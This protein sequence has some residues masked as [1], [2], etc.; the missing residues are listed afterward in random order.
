MTPEQVINKDSQTLNSKKTKMKINNKLLIAALGLGMVATSC[1]KHDILNEIVE[2]GQEVPTAYWEVSSTTCKAGEE[3]TFQGKYTV[4]YDGATPDHAQVWYRVNRSESAAASVALAG[5][6]LS[7][8]KTV[9]SENVMRDFT[10]IA[11]FPHSQATWDGHEFILI[12]SVP[13]S[14][15]LSPVTWRD[16]KTYEDRLYQAYYPEGFDKEFCTEVVDML[17]KDSY[18]NALR[19]VYI[20]YPFTNAQFAAVNAKYGTDLPCEFDESDAGK[21]Q[22]DKSDAWFSTTEANT[23]NLTGYYYTTLE[24]DETIYHEVAKDDVTIGED[25]SVTYNDQRCYPVYKSAAWVFCRYDDNTGSIVSSVRPAYMPA[26]K[27]L[28]E[29]ISFSEWIFDSTENVYRVDFLRK[30]SLTTSFRVYDSNGE[31]GIAS[32]QHEISIN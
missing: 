31:E 12:G 9:T 28:I 27:E 8:T 21:M 30:Y 32:D 13:V 19:T 7:Y 4:G 26:F 10:P 3:F 2:P 23:K 24:G 29:Q 5:T 22:S 15:T 14:R 20:N 1:A 17:T 18:Y 16:A 6:S 11:T 25:G